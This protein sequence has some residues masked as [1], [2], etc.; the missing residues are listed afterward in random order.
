M[1]LNIRM[2][3]LSPPSAAGGSRCRLVVTPAC[4]QT[5]TSRDR[6]R[7]YIQTNHD[8]KK[9]IHEQRHGGWV[10][11][12]IPQRGGRGSGTRAGGKH[13]GKRATEAFSLL[14][15]AFQ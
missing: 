5:A 4:S 1:Q 8:I 12:D 11:S 9:G 6:C 2:P 13:S 15:K 10:A 14:L 7:V 3:P